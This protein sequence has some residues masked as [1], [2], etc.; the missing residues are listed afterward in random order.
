MKKVSVI[1]PV[2]NRADLLKRAINSTL[3]QSFPPLE[4]LVCDDG[5]TDNNFEIIKS[6]NNPKVKWIAGKHSGLPAVVRNRGIRKSKGEWLAFLD[7]DDEWLPTKLEKQLTFAQQNE[8]LAVSSNAFLIRKQNNFGKILDFSKSVIA[9]RDLLNT[10]FII[11]SSVIIHKSLLKK[12]EGFP[13]GPS[14]IA[15]EDYALWLRIATQ[16]YFGY[17]REP[18]MYY[19]DNIHSVRTKGP[20]TLI[21]QKEIVYKNFLRWIKHKNNLINYRRKVETALNYL[22]S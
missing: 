17:I 22:H 21:E 12:C 1:I 5:S 2:W 18:L 3:N 6:L 10:N 15:T 9:F 16:T 4:I 20:Q 7:S 19:N 8:L 13:E 14:L 11:C